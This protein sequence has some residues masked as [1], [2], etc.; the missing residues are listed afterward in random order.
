M[1]QS[2][3]PPSDSIFEFYLA[4]IESVTKSKNQGFMSKFNQLVYADSKLTSDEKFCL[5][6]EMQKKWQKCQT[7]ASNTL[8]SVPMR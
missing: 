5:L 1:E 7:D 3:Q 2:S 4:V 6:G 8:K